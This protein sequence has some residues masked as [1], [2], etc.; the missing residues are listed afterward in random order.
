MTE[1]V[2][3]KQRGVLDAASTLVKRTGHGPSVRDIARELGVT[4]ATVQGHI[5]ELERK[6]F[7]RR[8]G[9]AFGLELID[10]GRRRSAGSTD[11]VVEVAIVGRI[12]A[13]RPVE[14]IE[15]VSD[16]ISVPRS[17]LRGESF[18]LRVR[19]DSMRDDAILDGDLVIVQK[20]QTAENGEI[21]VALLEDG[22]ATLKR[23]YREARGIRLQPANETLEPIYVSSVEVQGVVTGVIRRFGEA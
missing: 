13:G 22:S 5:V 16:R 9:S 3:R 10:Q 7:V 21:V 8:S 23:I 14:A 1:H 12:A 20:R 11:E 6:G 2:T 4:A 18:A 19:G 17:M 15:D